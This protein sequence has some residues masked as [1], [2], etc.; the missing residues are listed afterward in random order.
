M[1]RFTHVLAPTFQSRQRFRMVHDGLEKRGHQAWDPQTEAK[2]E[3]CEHRLSRMAKPPLGLT[4]S[5]EALERLLSSFLSSRPARPRDFDGGLELPFSRTDCKDPRSVGKGLG[6]NSCSTGPA[7]GELYRKSAVLQGKS[8]WR[9][10]IWR[11]TVFEHQIR[12]QTVGD[13]LF[14]TVSWRQVRRNRPLIMQLDTFFETYLQGT[15]CGHA[16]THFRTFHQ[17]KS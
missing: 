7:L 8:P 11:S 9:T 10:G 6:A 15:H 16:P 1:W 12:S 14:G 17:G 2:K 4:L 13:S 3:W 5:G